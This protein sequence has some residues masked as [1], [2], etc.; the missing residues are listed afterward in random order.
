LPES[1]RGW[2]TAVLRTHRGVPIIVGTLFAFLGAFIS[3]GELDQRW[4]LTINQWQQPW[5]YP[6]EVLTWSALGIVA[7]FFIAALS[8]AQPRRVAAVLMAVVV[9][10]LW[11]HAV[12]RLVKDDRPLVFYGLD[13]PTFHVVGD[14]LRAHGMPSGHSVSAM[15]LAGLMS[16][17]LSPQWSVWQRVLWATFWWAVGGAQVV[18]RIVVGAHWPSDVLV[19]SAIG[20]AVVPMVWH[21]PLTQRFGRWLG[22]RTQRKVMAGLMPLWAVGLVAFPQGCSITPLVAGALLCLGAWGGWRWWHSA[23]PVDAALS[24][25]IA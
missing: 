11:V 16:L 22:G 7:F 15:V 5:P 3:R 20:L 13:H 21:L 2:L 10:G 19:G 14:L 1:F 8:S 23:R 12:K 17:G 6:W 9:G 24:D 25:P 18:S 4:C